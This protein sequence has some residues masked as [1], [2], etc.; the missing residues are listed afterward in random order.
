MAGRISAETSAAW[1]KIV[2]SAIVIVNCHLGHTI[3]IT[4]LLLRG[5]ENFLISMS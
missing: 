3:F 1:H 5:K 2:A 4:T